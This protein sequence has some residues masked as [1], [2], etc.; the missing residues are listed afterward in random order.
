MLRNFIIMINAQT[1]KTTTPTLSG[2][3]RNN[4]S[5]SADLTG[6]NRFISAK[7][8]FLA[9][10]FPSPLLPYFCTVTGFPMDAAGTQHNLYGTDSDPIVENSDAVVETHFTPVFSYEK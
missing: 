6:L 10:T 4:L 8:D 2:L 7:P 5:G 1:Y 9:F 3:Y